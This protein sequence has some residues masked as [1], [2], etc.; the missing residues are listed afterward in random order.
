MSVELQAKSRS[1]NRR[2][3][4]ILLKKLQSDPVG[5][6]VTENGKELLTFAGFNRRPALF[7]IDK[8]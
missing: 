2:S 6:L 8:V 7:K 4:E 3:K 5:L 1:R